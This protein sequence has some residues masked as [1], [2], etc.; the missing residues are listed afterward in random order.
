MI[1]NSPVVTS[2]IY[3]RLG[4]LELIGLEEVTSQAR[5]IIEFAST[6][7][8]KVME[9][10]VPKKRQHTSR[11]MNNLEQME[12]QLYKTMREDLGVSGLGPRTSS[13]DRL[14]RRRRRWRWCDGSPDREGSEGDGVTT[15][16]DRD[17][18]LTRAP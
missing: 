3:D 8:D 17:S 10:R 5:A 12:K 7:F 13:S 2:A 4:E 16:G 11:P 14:D 18:E 1:L 6:S 9:R 15:T